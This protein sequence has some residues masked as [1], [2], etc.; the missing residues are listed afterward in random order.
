M[1]KEEKSFVEGLIDKFRDGE[2]SRRQLLKLTTAA[3]AIGTLQRYFP[4]WTREASGAMASPGCGTGNFTV[5]PVTQQLIDRA[6]DLNITI[7]WDRFNAKE[8]HSHNEQDSATCINCQQGP[9][10][11]VTFGVCGASKDLIISRNLLMETARGASAHAGHARR[12]A[13]T[14]KLVAEGAATGYYIKDSAKLDAIYQ[15]LGLSG[16]SSSEEK[17]LAVAH[18]TFEDLTKLEGTPKWLTYKANNERQDKW[19]DLTW[20]SLPWRSEE[21][22]VGK[23]CRSRW[24][25]YH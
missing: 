7:V 16:E 19:S 13:N 20:D 18:A 23:E 12:V 9:C 1:G 11:K 21:R 24:S 3:G 14:L 15:G 8:W 25:P 4:D 17:A 6:K 10:R 5:D 2:I 22:R